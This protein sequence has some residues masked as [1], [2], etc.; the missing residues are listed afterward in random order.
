MSLA[1]FILN[2]L[3]AITLLLPAACTPRQPQEAATPAGAP[4]QTPESVTVILPTSTPD[5]NAPPAAL[6]GTLTPPQPATAAP[7]PTLP[8]EITTLPAYDPA[9]TPLA[10]NTLVEGLNLPVGIANA[11]DGSGRLF[12]IE[13]PGR[14]RVFDHG[15]LLDTPFL[16]ITDRVGSQANE[17]GLLGL[18]FPPTYAQ[19][20]QFFVNYTDTNGDSVISRF[21]VTADANRA[22]SASESV[23]LTLDQPAANHNGG[24]LVFGPDAKLWIGTGDGG[25]AN[26]RFG[27][28]Q[29]PATLLGKMLRI[30]VTSDPAQPY[31]IPAD[32]P[33]IDASWNGQDVRDEIWALGLRNPW[34]YSF[35]RATGDLWIADVGQNQYEEVNRTPATD[36]GGGLNYGWPIMEAAHCFQQANC[37]QDGLVLPILEYDHSGHCSITGG[38]VYRGQAIPDLVG[39]YLFGD[40][41]S[42]FIWAAIPDAAGGWRSVQAIQVEA[43]LTSFGEDEAGDLYIVDY[44]GRLSRIVAAQ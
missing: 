5:T 32:N 38:Y 44:A 23:V 36:L 14:I 4:A 39:A 25:S 43:P 27:N 40:Y 3:L 42:G 10:L 28:G 31:T 1:R 19:T 21:T 34:R 29:N 13:K 16:D 35:D 37:V 24:N 6:P 7:T 2:A 15:V 12:V 18:A 8:V 9:R 20:G 11:A 33:W 41:C 26:D 30:D 22:D 17:Q